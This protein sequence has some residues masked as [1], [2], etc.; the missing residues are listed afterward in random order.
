[1]NPRDNWL[2]T[3]GRDRRVVRGGAQNPRAGRPRR[4]D[5]ECAAVAGVVPGDPLGDR[6][7]AP[8]G[9]F[10]ARYPEAVRP[11]DRPRRNLVVPTGIFRAPKHVAIDPP[12]PRHVVRRPLPPSPPP[13][14]LHARRPQFLGGIIKK[15]TFLSLGFALGKRVESAKAKKRALVARRL[16]SPELLD[17]RASDSLVAMGG[18]RALMA[19]VPQWCKRPNFETTAW[20]NSAIKTLWPRLSAALSKTLGNVLSRRLSRVSPLGMSLRIKE[21][22]LGSESLNSAQREQRRGA[23]EEREHGRLLGGSGFGR[24]VD[25]EPPRSCS[26]SGI[27]GCRSP[28]GCPGSQVRSIHW[29]PYDRVGVVNA[30]P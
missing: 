22:Q 24:S 12:S 7:R 5:G 29:F 1:M 28:C 21:F 19:D 25:R 6:R 17:H 3:I 16:L 14:S 9:A 11:R 26:R 8:G 30:D 18:L 27:A 13:P 20:L 10:P 4:G 23:Q 2:D 15:A